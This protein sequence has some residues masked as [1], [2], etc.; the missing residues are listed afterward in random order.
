MPRINGM[1]RSVLLFALFAA[2]PLRA[3]DLSGFEKILLP[4]ITKGSISGAGGKFSA[5]AFVYS[6]VPCRIAGAHFLDGGALKDTMSG[7]G[8]LE[9]DLPGSSRAF[10][11]FIYVERPCAQQVSILLSA[12]SSAG[13]IALAVPRER[14]WR[15]GKT[16][17]LGAGFFYRNLTTPAARLKLRVFDFDGTGRGEILVRLIFLPYLITSEQR[18]LLDRRDGDDAGSPFYAELDL[19]IP[20]SRITTHQPDCLSFSIRVETVALSPALRY[21]ALLT[22]TDNESQQI[23]APLPQP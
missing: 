13:S 12:A 5:V 23:F 8:W 2:V 17:F 15:S 11:R 3:D 9:V 14:D 10:G 1:R 16:V 19:S 6:P 18:V 7:D 21:W 4:V 22:S 20:C